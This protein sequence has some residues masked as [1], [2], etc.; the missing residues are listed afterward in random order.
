[1]TSPVV[2]GWIDPKVPRL[3]PDR[4]V[5]YVSHVTQVLKYYLLSNILIIHGTVSLFDQLSLIFPEII[6]SKTQS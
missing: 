1:M 2:A 5:G 3:Q 6:G 4:I